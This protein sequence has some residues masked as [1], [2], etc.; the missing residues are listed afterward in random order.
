MKFFTTL[1]R[2]PTL[3]ACCIAL[4]GTSVSWAGPN[5]GEESGPVTI[6][7]ILYESHSSPEITKPNQGEAPVWTTVLTVPDASY[8]APHFSSFNL[9]DE[10]AWLIVRGTESEGDYDS[11][12]RIT[13]IGIG[14]SVGSELAP[15]GWWA[16]MAM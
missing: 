4:L 15:A 6:G 8:I 10:E 13:Y 12:R 5:K 16:T 9:P 14:K 11:V 1:R 7:E 3:A 2:S